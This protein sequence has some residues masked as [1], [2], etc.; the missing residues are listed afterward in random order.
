MQN[1]LKQTHQFLL[2][3][4]SHWH[5]VISF[6]YYYYVVTIIVIILLTGLQAGQDNFSFWVHC[7]LLGVAQLHTPIKQ[8]RL[9]WGSIHLQNAFLMVKPEV[10]VGMSEN[11][12][13]LRA[14]VQNS[15]IHFSLQSPGQSTSHAQ[16]QN[17]RRQRI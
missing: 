13:H 8:P 3:T 11:I 17:Q 16:S 6:Y 7:I 5:P 9:I 10:P 12:L 4:I 1:V 14:S 2:L 15:H